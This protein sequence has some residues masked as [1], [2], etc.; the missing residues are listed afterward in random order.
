MQR[1]L[2]VYKVYSTMAFHNACLVHRGTTC[3]RLETFFQA[4]SQPMAIFFTTV[5]LEAS[6]SLTCF[7]SSACSYLPSDQVFHRNHICIVPVLTYM[8]G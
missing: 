2:C 5:A 7:F 8:E 6:A 4:F 3:F 1:G